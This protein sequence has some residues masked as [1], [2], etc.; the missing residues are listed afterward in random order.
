[1]RQINRCH[2]PADAEREVMALEDVIKSKPLEYGISYFN[3]LHF[4]KIRNA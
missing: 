1:M 4:A 3:E 2:D